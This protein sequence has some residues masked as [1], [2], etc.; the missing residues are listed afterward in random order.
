[1]WNKAAMLNFKFPKVKSDTAAPWSTSSK[2]SGILVTFSCRLAVRLRYQAPFG[3]TGSIVPWSFVQSCNKFYHSPSIS[4]CPAA[5]TLFKTSI[6]LVW[7][8]CHTLAFNTGAQLS[9]DRMDESEMKYKHMPSIMGW[10]KDVPPSL[11]HHHHKWT[12]T[13]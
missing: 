12:L 13:D 3:Q 11:H 4:F 7:R 6:L 2:D 1:M 8:P 10:K 5:C 9:Y